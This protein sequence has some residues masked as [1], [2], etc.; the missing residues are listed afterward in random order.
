MTVRLLDAGGDISTSGQQFATER[1]EIAQT[2]QTRLRLFLGEYFRDVTDGTPWWESIL[3]KEG[4]LSS[5]EAIIKSRIVRTEG[6]EQLVEFSTDF[7]INTRV[8][9]VSAGI[10]TQYGTTYFTVSV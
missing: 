9:S 1:E 6:V 4:T 8:Y 10:L 5:K 2:V 7:D 3:G